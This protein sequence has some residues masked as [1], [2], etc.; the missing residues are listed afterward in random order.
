MQIIH[1]ELK[2]IAGDYVELRYFVDNPNQYERRRSS[3]SCRQTSLPLKEIADLIELAER[4][5]YVSALPEDYAVT[6]RRLYNWLDGSDRTLQSL[7]DNHR[8][9]GVVLAINT[10][11]VET[12]FI[13]SS[14]SASP[15]SPSLYH[16]PWEVLHD[17]TS[18]LVQRVP[19]IV[20]VRW[21]SDSKVKKLTIDGEPENRALNVLFMATSP[22]NV[23]PV[24]DFEAE[25]GRILKATARQPLAL[26]VEESG[27]LSE[28]GYL[29]RANAS[30]VYLVTTE[31][32]NQRKNQHLSFE[33][34]SKP[35][36]DR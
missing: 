35:Q 2:H 33:P 4:D 29:V 22:L 11:L 19:A 10:E 15:Q 21:V 16:L 1:L 8:R 34:L 9:E 36:S 12:R 6:G 23:E 7:L 3:A 5:Y 14:P 13:A 24:L 30:K 31:I 20:P 17:G 18:F 28:L 32:E 27:C 25:E 26:T